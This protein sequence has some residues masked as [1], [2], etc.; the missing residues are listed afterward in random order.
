MVPGNILRRRRKGDRRKPSRGAIRAL[1]FE[2]YASEGNQFVNEV[3]AI[4][5]VRRNLAAR[6]TRAV[7]QAVR[8]RLPP[9]DAVQFGQGLPM[10]L[11]GVYFDQYDLSRAPVVIRAPRQFL[12]FVRSKDGIVGFNDCPGYQFIE[13]AMLAVFT[14]LEMHMDLGQIAQIRRMMNAE[15]AGMTL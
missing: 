6:V 15:I 13:A 3:A 2:K 11:K 9:D 10:A 5:D 14:V 8:D 4:L 1:N 12:D 7:L